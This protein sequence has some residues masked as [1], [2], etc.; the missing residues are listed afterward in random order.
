[1]LSW[2][3]EFCE[4][5]NSTTEKLTIISY[6]STVKPHL[7]MNTEVAIESVC[8]NTESVFSRNKTIQRKCKGFL[9]PGTKNT[10][11]NNEVSVLLSRCP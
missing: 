1:M 7:N 6:V 5:D 2:A 3:P 11:L 10:V 4:V 9:S 8:I